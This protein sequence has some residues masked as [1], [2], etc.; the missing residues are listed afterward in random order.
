MSKRLRLVSVV[1]QPMVVID[2]G[3]E[4]T[5]AQ[6]QPITF[7]AADWPTA[8]ER[9]AADLDNEERRLNGDEQGQG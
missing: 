9:L 6:V 7:T 5:P 8:S 1:V 4:L 2:D 3:S